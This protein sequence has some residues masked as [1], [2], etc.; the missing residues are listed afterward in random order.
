MRQAAMLKGQVQ[1]GSGYYYFATWEIGRADLTHLRKKVE[2]RRN[3]TVMALLKL[4]H[5]W[6]GEPENEQKGDDRPTRRMCA[7]RS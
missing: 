7:E 2:V 5:D 6:R 1:P 3:L 4:A